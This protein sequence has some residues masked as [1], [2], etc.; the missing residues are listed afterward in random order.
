MSD[1]HSTGALRQQPEAVDHERALLEL[2]ALAAGLHFH[3]HRVGIDYE[4][5][6][7][8][9]T[10]DSDDWFIWSPLTDDGDA[11]RLAATLKLNI[12]Q[13]D[14]SVGVNNEAD[15]DEAA[16]VRNDDERL[17]VLRHAIVRAAAQIGSELRKTAS[18][19]HQEARS[20]EQGAST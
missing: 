3:G 14:F 8:S 11:L 9:A 15:V 12:L 2:A 13:G 16:L 4:N 20:N 6:Y 18:C 19:S 10:G 5:C 1:V 17:A 7:V